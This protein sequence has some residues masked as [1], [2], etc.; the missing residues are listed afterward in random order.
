MKNN[1]KLLIKPSIVLI[2]VL[3]SAAYPIEYIM[4]ST[5]DLV[6]IEIVFRITL[7]G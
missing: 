6:L 7:Q 3:V 1:Y 5:A 4:F 2:F